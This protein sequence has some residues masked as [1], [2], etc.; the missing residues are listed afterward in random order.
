MSDSLICVQS[1]TTI[2][3]LPGKKAAVIEYIKLR[4][5]EI[6]GLIFKMT[7]VKPKAIR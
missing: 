6:P 1:V 2:S 5:R 7:E 3:V 4:G